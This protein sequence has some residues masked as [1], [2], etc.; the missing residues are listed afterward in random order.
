MCT[1]T[2][3]TLAHVLEENG[4]A[5]AMIA[6][7]RSQVER[8]HPPRALYCDFPLGR[9]LGVPNDAPFQHRVL[10]TLL[11]LFAE[12]RTPVL[13]DFPERITDSADEPLSCAIPPRFDPALPPAVDETLAYRLAYERQRASSGRTLVGRVLSADTV[14][15]AVAALVRIDEG[16]PWRD[17]DLPGDLY[18][19]ALDIRAYFEEAA[20][21]LADHVPGARSAETWF[22]QATEAGRLIRRVRQRLMDADEPR[23]VWFSMAPRNQQ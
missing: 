23:A 11:D 7:M 5:T 15:A 1:R 13:R 19:V 18:A 12:P 9:P 2:V 10:R 14:P 8:L 22:F 17:V 3:G 20:I 6:S 16:T 21:A 4:I